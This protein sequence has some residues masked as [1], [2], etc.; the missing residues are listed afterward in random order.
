MFFKHEK[1]GKHLSERI[2]PIFA[3]VLLFLYVLGNVQVESFHQAF[4]SLEKALHSTEQEKDPCHRA[5]Y[6]EVTKEGCDHKTHLTAP[7]KCP[8]CHVVPVNEQHLAIYE[9]FDVFTPSLEIKGYSPS[10]D[11][12]IFSIKLPSRAPP[13]F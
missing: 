9:S 5:I 12:V 6:H 13:I 2:K 7:K 4:H 1:K 3:A 8:L 11:K 10:V